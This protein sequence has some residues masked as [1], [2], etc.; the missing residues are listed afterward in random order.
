MKSTEEF[1]KDL[2]TAHRAAKKGILSHLTPA[3]RLVGAFI[4][5]ITLGTLF[6]LLPWSVP[7]DQPLSWIDALFTATSAV[8]VTG[9]IVRDTATSFAPFGQIVILVLIQVGGLGYMILATMAAALLGRRIGVTDQAAIKQALNLE[10]GE[11]MAKFIRDVVMVTLTL[12]LISAIVITGAYWGGHT[13][14]RAIALGVFHSVSGF[15]NAG[16]C[17]F[18]DNLMGQGGQ[19]LAV[20]AILI[21]AMIGGLGYVVIHELIH[22]VRS[23]HK[24]I[25]LH[26]KLVLVTTVS[27]TIM[28]AVLLYA[29]TK[30]DWLHAVFLSAV[31]RT[32]GF[33]IQDTGDLPFRAIPDDSPDV[34]RG[35]AGRN[36]RRHQDHH[37][38]HHVSGY[39]GHAPGPGGDYS[40][41][42]AGFPRGYL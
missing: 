38:C 24:K 40:V 21:L 4:I 5:V 20:I 29:T 7:K 23:P 36:R 26:T 27:L 1:I 25:S 32:A 42:A 8:C 6:L 18:S 37:F 19:P 35:F 11:G 28:G 10:T 14:G 13:P 39:L 16:F 22:W 31:A 15:N 3:L 17:L 41:S 9:L 2:F 34:Y 30:M 12:E 33:N